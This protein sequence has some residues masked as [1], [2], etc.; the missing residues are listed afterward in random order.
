MK[1]G[2]HNTAMKKK[3]GKKRKEIVNQPHKMG[4]WFADSHDGY[5][6]RCK[7]CGITNSRPAI[8]LQKQEQKEEDD[9]K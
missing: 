3:K 4:T 5:P 7:A 1:S 2:Q 8:Q 9:K 6:C